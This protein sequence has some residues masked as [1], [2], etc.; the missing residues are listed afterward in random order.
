MNTSVKESL[1][2][3]RRALTM[4]WKSSPRWSA[5]N[6]VMVVLRGALPLLMLW[7]IKQLI[8][9]ISL[10]VMSN[11]GTSF[12][13]LLPT[14]SL[15]ALFFGTNALIAS[16][17]SIVKEK[18][19]HLVSDYI[20][21]LVHN[22]TTGIK[23]SYFENSNYQ[24]IFY[25]AI[26]EAGFRPARIFYSVAGLLQ[27]FITLIIIG[28][29]LLSIHPAM[30]LAAV[31][32][33]VPILIFR[34][35]YSRR[36]YQLLREQTH[37]E[38]RV[39][40]YNRVITSREFAKEI[41][42]FD[43]GK[44]F[45]Q[46]FLDLR[47]SL[48]SKQMALIIK[49][50]IRE[51]LLQLFVA[52]MMIAVFGYVIYNTIKGHFTIGTMTMYFVA[53][54]RGYSVLQDFLSR[55]TSLYED[56]LFLKNFF[57]FLNIST[58]K[59]NK[60]RESFPVPFNS[61]IEL[62]NVSFTYPGTERTVLDNISLKINKGETVAIVGNNGSGKTTLVKLLCG[63]YEPTSGQILVDNVQLKNISR[64]ELSQ[65]ITVIFQDFMLYNV[66]ARENIWFGNINHPGED[67]LI[68]EAASKAGIDMLFKNMD[69]GYDTNLGT[70]FKDS[71][72]LSQGEWQRTALARAFFNNASI[73]I[74]DEPTSS[75]DAFT[76]A[77]IIGN[78][79]EITKDKTAII[80]SHRLSSISMA[81]RVIVVDNHRIA[82]SGTPQELMAANGIFSRM[83]SQ[84]EKY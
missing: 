52:M 9:Q 50:S 60:E 58:G 77:E 28:F 34:I 83:I 6:L 79:K 29:I 16:I 11:I 73:I 55:I 26:S 27:N 53:L 82:E 66:S 18:Q 54:Q 78:F 68:N 1:S 35:T 49:K 25:R 45:R 64:N 69:K 46:R 30:I 42:V 56:N 4:I 74:L 57:E 80:I 33:S 51:T 65:N 36:F 39:D 70:L 31:L 19:S 84:L 37:D 75:L 8:D 5:A 22:K 59:D 48:R 21:S 20:T 76:E 14:L 44:L 71:Q 38:R 7:V 12:R 13:V 41:R 15:T 24:D 47:K 72:Q 61:G 63:L 17:H 3:I 81:D 67:K 40:Y 32:I 62:K 43:L 23:Y 2:Y 10:Q